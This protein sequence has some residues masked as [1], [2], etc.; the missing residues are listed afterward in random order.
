M[1]SCSLDL[2]VLDALSYDRY[3]NYNHLLKVL[4]SFVHP[5]QE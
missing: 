1:L 5:R 3:A 2:D 4:G